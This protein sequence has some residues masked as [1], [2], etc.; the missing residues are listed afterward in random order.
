MKKFIAIL[1]IFLLISF[2]VNI[3]TAVAQPK[4]F[5][6][7]FYTLKDLNLMENTPYTV[8]NTSHES[9]SLLVVLDSNQRVQQVMRL[10][11]NSPKYTAMPLRYDYRI[12]IIGTGDLTFS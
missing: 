5:S 12:I 1:S 8:Q 9:Y 2:S 10:D 3:S 7:G 11:P 4:S 6:E